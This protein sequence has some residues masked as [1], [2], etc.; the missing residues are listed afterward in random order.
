MLESRGN[1]SVLAV[2]STLQNDNFAEG[3]RKLPKGYNRKS[4]DYFEARLQRAQELS[5]SCQLSFHVSVNTVNLDVITA[6]DLNFNIQN[7]GFE[8]VHCNILV[9][10]SV[11]QKLDHE[12]RL[13]ATLAPNSTP[14]EG[15]ALRDYVNTSR[16]YY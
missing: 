4:I 3:D 16:R 10:F 6:A 13:D 12:N 15:S 8:T 2:S 11:I 9:V 7:F 14:T 1:N 5:A